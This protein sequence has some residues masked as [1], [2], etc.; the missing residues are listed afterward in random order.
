VFLLPDHI[1]VT[2]TARHACAYRALAVY[3][4]AN[5]YITG[6]TVAYGLRSHHQLSLRSY[7]SFEVALAAEEV[8]NLGP[9]LRGDERPR[10]YIIPT[11]GVYRWRVCC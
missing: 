2:I 3:P 11:Y 9:T 8:G 7:R 5:E 1:I 4:A 10:S 6:V